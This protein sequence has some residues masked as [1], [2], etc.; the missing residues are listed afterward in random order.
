VQGNQ[1]WRG[2]RGYPRSTNWPLTSACGP[3]LHNHREFSWVAKPSS[4]EHIACS[5]MATLLNPAPLRSA[6]DIGSKRTVHR[7]HLAS[8]KNSPT[9]FTKPMRALLMT[10]CTPPRLRFC[11]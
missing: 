11:G 8:G 1:N 6:G 7:C 4:K 10:N 3:R 9:A 2:Y 5:T